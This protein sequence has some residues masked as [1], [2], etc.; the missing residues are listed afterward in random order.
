[1]SEDKNKHNEPQGDIDPLT[2]YPTTGHDWDG[3]KELN[4]PSPRWWLLV[5]LACIIWA[6]GYW[7][8]Y[9]AWPIPGGNTKGTA[10]WNEYKQLKEDQKV[11][12][13]RKQVY[14]DKFDKASFNEI[15]NNDELYAFAIAGGA[16]AFKNNCAMCH[17]SGGSGGP[18]YPNL[19]DD[20]W[21]WGGKIEDIYKTLQHGIRYEADADTRMS[22]MPSFGRDGLLKRKQIV[23]VVNFVQSLS[24][25][26]DP[27]DKEDPQALAAS[28]ER[29]SQ[30]FA[31]NCAACHGPEGKGGR[32]VGA[33]NLS[34]DIWLYGGD[35]DT[36][37]ETVYN[38]RAGVM[39]AWRTRLNASTIRQLAVYVHQLGGGEESAESKKIMLESVEGQVEQP[40]FD[41]EK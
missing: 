41:N 19:N 23:D 32:E 22:M 17:G 3:L 1:M 13:D 9:P 39:P 37:F 28:V 35:K 4:I 16:I 18:G 29:G 40:A 34:D 30:I 5:F 11:I 25:H 7:F 38:A 33:P 26:R 8:V 15:L 14:Q 2:G 36:L 10:E 12:A 21:L 20:D 31:E 6:V 27:G 24:G